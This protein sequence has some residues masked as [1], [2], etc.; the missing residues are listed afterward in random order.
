MTPKVNGY[1]FWKT[2]LRNRRKEETETGRQRNTMMNNGT[3]SKKDRHKTF[4]TMGLKKETTQ[5]KI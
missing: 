4:K 3:G 1:V 5:V 2:H